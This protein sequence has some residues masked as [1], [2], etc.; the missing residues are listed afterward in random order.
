MSNAFFVRGAGKEEPIT[1][2]TGR[3]TLAATLDSLLIDDS[4][5]MILGCICASTAVKSSVINLKS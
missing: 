3:A 2:S 5:F 1:A 4:R